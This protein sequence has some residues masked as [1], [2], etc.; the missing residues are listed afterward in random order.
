[1]VNEFDMQ[2]AFNVDWDKVLDNDELDEETTRLYRRELDEIEVTKRRREEED[3]RPARGGRRGARGPRS[4]V[5]IVPSRGR[6]KGRRR[7]RGR[8]TRT[9]GDAGRYRDEA[10]DEQEMHLGAR[11]GGSM[12]TNDESNVTARGSESSDSSD[13]SDSGDSS[14]GSRAPGAAPEPHMPAQRF[15]LEDMLFFVVPGR[16]TPRAGL[17]GHYLKPFTVDDDD[18]CVPFPPPPGYDPKKK[19]RL[20]LEYDAGLPGVPWPSTEAVEL[21]MPGFDDNEE[22]WINIVDQDELKKACLPY[23][24]RMMGV[25]ADS[26]RI[27]ARKDADTPFMVIRK[28]ICGKHNALH[29][30]G[31]YGFNDPSLPPNMDVC[32][33]GVHFMACPSPLEDPRYYEVG[34]EYLK[35]TVERGEALDFA[36]ARRMQGLLGTGQDAV[37]ACLDPD[38]NPADRPGVMERFSGAYTAGFYKAVSWEDSHDPRAVATEALQQHKAFCQASRAASRAPPCD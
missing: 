22:D 21:V 8:R 18:E 24:S 3:R 29:H 27:V 34:S 7:G 17:F 14:E 9:S 16:D 38:F 25:Y 2:G 31:P 37:W 4:P 10:D 19:K 23:F 13:T 33:E 35:E 15:E 36:F 26:A 1:M 28:Y 32:K 5:R 30:S 20:D 12:L 6:S 11:D